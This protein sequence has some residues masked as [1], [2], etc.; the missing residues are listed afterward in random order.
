MAYEDLIGTSPTNGRIISGPYGVGSQ[1]VSEGI[2]S[3]IGRFL[4]RPIPNYTQGLADLSSVLGGFSQGEKADRGMRGDWTQNYDQLMLQA[5]H[6][7]ERAETDALA[8]LAN[9]N[10]IK[11][12]GAPYKPASLTLG[13]QPQSLPAFGFGPRALSA[14]QHVGAD[15]LERQMLDRLQP[16]GSYTPTNVDEYAKPGTMERIGSY[17]GAA[18]GGLGAINDLTGGKAMDWIG[19]LFGKGGSGAA[20]SAAGAAGSAGSAAGG[21]AGAAG[22]G[23]I[24][25]LMGQAMPYVGIGTGALGLMKDRGWAGNM[26]SGA[27]TGAGIGT[28]VAP[29]VGTAIGAGIGALGGLLRGIGGGPSEAEKQGRDMA[30]QLRNSL[31]SMATMG[32]KAEAGGDEGALLHIIVRDRALSKGLGLQAAEQQATQAVRSLWESE[33]GGAGAV[34][35]AGNNL[36][37]MLG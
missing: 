24:A 7:R 12:G 27:S 34:Q 2:E 9:T 26:A 13:G 6:A 31:G 19:G 35:Q 5:Q 21:A 28:L 15:R 14:A 11:S 3:G 18:I 33:K 37:G 4:P 22:G 23:G 25:G 20:G 30:G 29:G 16:D 17:G 1:G 36:V 32:Q 8:K 10:Y